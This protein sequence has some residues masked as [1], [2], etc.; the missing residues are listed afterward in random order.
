LEFN[1]F[2]LIFDER[3]EGQHLLKL[4]AEGNQENH[5]EFSEIEE[6]ADESCEETN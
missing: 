4:A 1:K 3:L 2:E 5:M 6:E